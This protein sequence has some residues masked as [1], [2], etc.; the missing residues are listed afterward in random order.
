MR[1][2]YAQIAEIGAVTAAL[3]LMMSLPLGYLSRHLEKR[4][5]PDED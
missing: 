1:T 2:D 5:E 3:Y 4:W